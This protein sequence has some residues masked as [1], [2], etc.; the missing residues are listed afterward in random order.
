MRRFAA[1]A[2]WVI[3]LVGV[4]AV[5]AAAVLSA[6]YPPVSSLGAFSLADQL[7]WSSAWLGF[8]LVGAVIL[9]QRPG[10]RIGWVLCGITFLVS[11]AVFAPSYARAAYVTGG[12]S[13]PLAGF[14]AWIG[15]WVFTA[16]LGLVVSLLLLFPTGTVA[17]RRARILARALAVVV[18]V[19]TV[20]YAFMP[21]PIEGDVPPVN[22]LGIESLEATIAT[23]TGHLG[24]VLAIITL[25]VVG[26]AV[27]RYRRSSGVE[28]QQFRW[29]TFAAAAFPL[30]FA[31]TIVLDELR[32]SGSFDPVVL[33]VFLG[34]N[35]LAAAIGIAVT[36]HGLYEIGRVV[37]RSVS[38]L[39]LTALL[40]TVYLVAVTVM[41]AATAPVTRESPVAVAAATL[42]A[43]ALF[44]PARRRIQ[45]IVDRR[46]NRAGYDAARTVDAYRLRLRDQVDV[47]ALADDLM[48]TISL[49]VQPAG[50]LLWLSAEAPEKSSP[51]RTSVTV[52]ERQRETKGT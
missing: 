1:A 34:A 42:V 33:V 35:G 8:G 6:R 5:A 3:W 50:A 13:F 7:W 28:R 45:A 32:P 11:L 19:D 38:Y 46:F 16:T 15:T 27:A 20:V 10:N 17:S 21:G 18:I 25:G 29:F 23:I 37:S 52:P 2:V 30:L 49:S 14:A 36:R 48:R 9:S 47:G 43:A 40:V 26:D 41:T 22:P 39:L 44:G 4:A 12:K 31:L 51:S 24:T